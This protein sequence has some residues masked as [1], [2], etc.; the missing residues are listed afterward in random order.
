M[1]S[2]RPVGVF[3]S[4]VGGLTVAAGIRGLLPGEALVYFGDTAHLPYGDKSAHAIREY[5]QQISSF[6]KDSGCKALVVACN[7]A[8][9]VLEPDFADKL[10]LPVI[11]VIDPVVRMVSGDPSLK[12]IGVIGTRR[13]VQSKVYSNGIRKLSPDKVVFE[14]A[15]PLLV[16]LIEEGFLHNAASRLILKHYLEQLPQ[17][18]A[19]I[20]GCTHYPLLTGDISE[21]LPDVRLIDAPQVVALELEHILEERALLNPDETSSTTF[22]VSDRTEVFEQMASHFFG[23][24]IHLREHPLP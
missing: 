13:T 11:D 14:V 5:V 12:R 16:P 7:S 24:E 15:T 21:L 6:L 2:N 23:A 4:G 1:H 8:A 22:Y 3:D 17:I 9:S 18:D 10:G 19:L 20:L